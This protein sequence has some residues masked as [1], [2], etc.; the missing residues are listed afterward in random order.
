[1]AIEV[2]NELGHTSY[3]YT[4]AEV[5][6]TLGINDGHG[7]PMGRNKFF[8]ALRFNKFLDANNQP[9][10]YYLT[11]GLLAYHPT[12]K[13]WKTFHIPVFTERGINYLRNHIAS[14]KF[15]IYTEPEK[16]ENFTVNIN[17]IV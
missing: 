5:C 12:K 8:R 2:I 11:M 6:K 16:K 13:Y 10:Q 9:Y 14:G 1:M 7:R 15:L 4:V 17:D 3:L